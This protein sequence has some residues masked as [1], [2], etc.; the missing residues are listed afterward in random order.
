LDGKLDRF[1]D[2][3]TLVAPTNDAFA[4]LGGAVLDSLRDP[5]N[6]QALVDILEY[7]IIIGVFTS[8]ELEDGVSLLTEQSGSIEVSIIE[9]SNVVE[10]MFNQATVVSSDSILAN[11]GILYK[12]DAVLNPNSVNGF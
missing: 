11:N 4:A 7:H 10:F 8:P 6:Q 3:L 12:I 2:E 9:D 1:G 5:E